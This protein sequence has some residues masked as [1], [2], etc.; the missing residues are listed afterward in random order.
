MA[1]V[2]TLFS[3]NVAGDIFPIFCWQTLKFI[4]TLVEAIKNNH[5]FF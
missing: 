3:L 4:D 2:I 1:K 5:G